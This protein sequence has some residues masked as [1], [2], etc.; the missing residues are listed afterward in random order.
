MDLDKITDIEVLRTMLK[1]EMVQMS[2][3]IE[4]PTR[5]YKKGEWFFLTQD[6]DGIFL[7]EDDPFTGLSLNYDEAEKYLVEF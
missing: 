1:N 3:T 6:E 4:T 5:T 2:K 7:W